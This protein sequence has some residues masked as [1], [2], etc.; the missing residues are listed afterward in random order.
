MHF[1]VEF[2][3]RVDKE[4]KAVWELT[5][6]GQLAHSEQAEPGLWKVQAYQQ[7]VL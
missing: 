7:S 4:G 3:R 2:M 5:G 6:S 1:Q